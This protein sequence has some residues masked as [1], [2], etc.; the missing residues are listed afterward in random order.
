MFHAGGFSGHI[1]DSI[2]EPKTVLRNIFWNS[3]DET[4]FF[5]I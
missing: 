4:Y 3:K 2:I 1:D 5:V